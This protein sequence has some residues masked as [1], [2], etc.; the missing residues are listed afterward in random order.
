MGHTILV[1]GIGGNVGQGI[2]RNIRSY[3][4]D[5]NI[6]GTNVDLKTVGNYLCDKVYQTPFAYDPKFLEVFIG[7]CE[8]ESVDLVI[9]STDFETLYLSKFRNEISATI[10]CSSFVSSEIFVDKYK[11]FLHF[12]E[13]EI[14]FAKSCLPSE[15]Y[16]QF[17]KVIA[18]PKSGRGSRGL[19]IDPENCSD[20]SDADYMIQEL[21][22]GI[23]YT[24]AFYINKKGEL[25]STI[26][27]ERDLQNG[28]TVFT[29]VTDEVNHLI[30]PII[31]KIISSMEVTG[32]C[33]IQYI[34]T[35]DK[36][37]IP[38]EINGRISGTNSIRQNFGFKDVHWTIEEYLLGKEL[39]QP[40]ITYG[41]A[42]RILLDVI[43]P[44]TNS[45]ESINS[46]TE[47]IIY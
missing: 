38:F 2:L 11:T 44:N 22:E 3:D 35:A 18:K 9:P 6:I 13:C 42:T 27:F 39:T 15:Y 19:F 12:S 33:N 7:V 10:A 37:C 47:K 46:Q 20:F 29:K 40:I 21:A 45:F 34:V 16:G 26:T 1:T 4:L 5:F 25:H 31:E 30:V 36:E 17:S 24:T 28:T 32:S 43:Y 14:A 41:I 23:E 8:K